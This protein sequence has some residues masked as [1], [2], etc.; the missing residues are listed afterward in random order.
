MSSGDRS[1]RLLHFGRTSRQNFRYYLCRQ[2]FRKSGN[3]EADTHLSPHCVDVAHRVGRGNRSVQ[4]GIINDWR[5]EVGRLN[6][7]PFVIQ[8]VDRRI[9]RFS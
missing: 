1:I 9:V 4:P 7:N 8:A 5:E 3:I 6:E 2:I